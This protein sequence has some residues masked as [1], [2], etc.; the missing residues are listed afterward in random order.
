[1]VKYPTEYKNKTNVA[2]FCQK[3]LNKK[4]LDLGYSNEVSITMCLEKKSNIATFKK[5]NE[6]GEINIKQ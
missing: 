4:L 3:R 5:W 6:N 2:I 1:M